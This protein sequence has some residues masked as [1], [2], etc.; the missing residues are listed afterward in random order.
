MA[1]YPPIILS[2]RYI[3]DVGSGFNRAVMLFTSTTQSG[4]VWGIKVMSNAR[5]DL[6]RGTPE[7]GVIKA[8]FWFEMS[9]EAGRWG[10]RQLQLEDYAG[11]RRVYN[12]MDFLLLG[13]KVNATFEIYG[14]ADRYVKCADAKR[15]RCKAHSQCFDQCH[16]ANSG[17]FGK[18]A[19]QPGYSG[20]EFACMESDLLAQHL[21]N[22]TIPSG[23]VLLSEQY[24]GGGYS[25]SQEDLIGRDGSSTSAPQADTSGGASGSTVSKYSGVDDGG[26]KWSHG[27]QLAVGLLCTIVLIACLLALKAFWR[28][29]VVMWGTL[30]AFAHRR[31]RRRTHPN[32]DPEIPR[33]PRQ[34]SLRFHAWHHNADGHEHAHQNALPH[35]LSRQETELIAWVTA[36]S[37][38]DLRAGGESRNGG[39]GGGGR[40]RGIEMFQRVG[41][42]QPPQQPAL[43]SLPEHLRSSCPPLP[44]PIH[45][46]SPCIYVV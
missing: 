45:S 38:R 10:L 1:F 39:R 16:H 44:L 46:L 22:G 3:K 34:P 11:N 17:C 21:T 31:D 2:C 37:E 36:L 9:D 23:L 18:C 6:V 19:C 35:H 28:G 15:L 27:G 29:H 41:S 30:N 8:P 14:R 12:D 5:T 24:D 33:V 7:G 20:N 43:V 13:S 25:L 26:L 32:A 40:G 4:E 42:Y